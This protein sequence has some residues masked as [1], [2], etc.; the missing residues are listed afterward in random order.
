MADT[1]PKDPQGIPDTETEEEK[2]P[3]VESLSAARR[4]RQSATAASAAPLASVQAEAPTTAG[5]AGPE[6]LEEEAHG[7]GAFNPETGEINWDCPCL[8]G[9]AHGPCGEQFR[10]AFSC[11]VF[12]TDEPKGINCIEH[13]KSMQDCFRAHPDLYGAEL[14][15]DPSDEELAANAQMAEDEARQAQTAGTAK[16]VAA[17]PYSGATEQVDRVPGANVTA[18]PSASPGSLSGDTGIPSNGPSSSAAKAEG[19]EKR[20]RSKK[21]TLQAKDGDEDELVPKAAHDARASGQRA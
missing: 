4:E 9:M 6:D 12:S 14:T 10:T 7:E 1:L 15:D 20:K 2:L 18:T 17:A 5:A 19:S 8:G 13:F 21:A 3:T 11:F 16:G